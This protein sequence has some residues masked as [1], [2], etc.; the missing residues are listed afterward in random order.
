MSKVVSQAHKAQT[1][2]SWGILLGLLC[3]PVIALFF[4][5]FPQYDTAWEVLL[6][7][8]GV[9][10]VRSVVGYVLAAAGSDPKRTEQTVTQAR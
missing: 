5:I 3:V 1:A 8:C 2:H 10:V 4:K 6:A 7:A 9:F